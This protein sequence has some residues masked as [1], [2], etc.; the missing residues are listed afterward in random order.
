M[1]SL[2]GIILGIILMILG[3]IFVIG[4]FV[5]LLGKVLNFKVPFLWTIVTFFAGRISKSAK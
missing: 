1:L 5:L 4:G 2:L 3:V